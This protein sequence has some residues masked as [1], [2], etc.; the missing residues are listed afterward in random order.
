MTEIAQGVE[1]VKTGSE[2]CLPP[3]GSVSLLNG[4][5]PSLSGFNYRVAETISIPHSIVLRIN[6]VTKLKPPTQA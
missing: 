3:N 1:P 5:C 2:S 4:H 6:T